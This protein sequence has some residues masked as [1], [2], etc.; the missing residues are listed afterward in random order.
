MPQTILVVDDEASVLK[1][2]VS[3]LNRHGYQTLTAV[4]G[5][6]ALHVYEAHAHEID[7]ILSDVLMPEMTGT[8]LLYR[9][10]SFGGRDI[11]KPVRVVLMTGWAA[12]LTETEDMAHVRLLHKPMTME[13]LL[14]VVDEELSR[15][16]G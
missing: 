11:A 9:I 8:E 13:A 10:L 7:L 16:V 5:I 15:K 6:E 12:G 1:V 2:V 14:R 3:I 4:N